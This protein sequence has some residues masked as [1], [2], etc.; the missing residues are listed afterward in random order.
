MQAFNILFW[1]IS[2]FILGILFFNLEIALFGFFLNL[3]LFFLFLILFLVFNSR[4]FFHAS[5]LSFFIIAGIFYASFYDLF[6]RKKIDDSFLNKSFDALVYKILA[7][8]PD[9]LVIVKADGYN[10]VLRFKY[11]ISLLPGDRIEFKIKKENIFSP[12]PYLKGEKLLLEIKNPEVIKVSKGK[13]FFSR[14]LYLK[15][16]AISNFSKLLPSDEAALLSGI[17]FGETSNFEYNLKEFMR[18]SGT[19]HIVALSGYNISI[20]ESAVIFLATLFMPRVAAIIVAGIFILIFIF[21]TGAE[22]SVVRAGIMGILILVA[23]EK[24]NLFDLRNVIVFS[25]LLMLI[26]NPDLLVFDIGFELSFLSLIGIIYIY[27]VL[28]NTKEETSFE[29]FESLKKIF[30]GTVSA[31]IAILPLIFKTFGFFSPFA[32][33][34]NLLILS[35]I[36]ITMFFGF[37]SSISG[38]F[39]L[40]LSNIFLLAA[41]PFLKWELMVIKFFGGLDFG[42]HFKV[43]WL[44]V[45]AYY[46]LLILFILWR[47]KQFKKY[48]I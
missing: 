4:R 38:L 48:I 27:P 31:Q 34:S 26:L 18:K 41:F 36:P 19:T 11:A 20:V 17:L 29:F 22:A 12:P 40:P 33:F 43:G 35:F 8:T 1:G 15:N 46:A 42:W 37:L 30:T 28:F 47:K 44:F 5:F 3:F 25:A 9:F 45:F 16:E 2:F 23:K 24:G 10:F 13:S 7:R 14:I 39:F 32:L 6:L 21:M